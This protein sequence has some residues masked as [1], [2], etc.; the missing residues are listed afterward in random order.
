MVIDWVSTLQEQSDFINEIARDVS[1]A[2]ATSSLSIEQARSISRSVERGAQGF[3]RI[4]DE[5]EKGNPDIELVEAAGA[6]ADTWTNLSVAT[7]NK[8]RTMQGK[9]PIEFPV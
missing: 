2:L 9:P 6:I 7:A 8:V 4:F 3:D 1:Q 5:L